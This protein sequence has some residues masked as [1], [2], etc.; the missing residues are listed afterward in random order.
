[1]LHYIKYI[2]RRIEKFKTN[3]KVKMPLTIIH[4]ELS[5]STNE[6]E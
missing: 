1:M 5:I 6:L 2:L 4:Q 3:L